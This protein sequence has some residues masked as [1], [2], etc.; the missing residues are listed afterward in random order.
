MKKEF[1]LQTVSHVVISIIT[2]E[3]SLDSLQFYVKAVTGLLLLLN[4]ALLM[5]IRF[6][7]GWAKQLAATLPEDERGSAW[8]KASRALGVLILVVIAMNSA[9]V[10][11]NYHLRQSADALV[12]ES[13]TSGIV[14]G[15]VE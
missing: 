3:T 7:M 12:G 4:L 10:Y 5:S 2:M 1:N 15:Q 13:A 8:A 11:A 14:V 6:G 9:A